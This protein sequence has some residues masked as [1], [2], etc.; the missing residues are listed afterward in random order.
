MQR[1]TDFHL[2]ITIMPHIMALV[3]IIGRIVI[4]V[5]VLI[6]MASGREILAGVD[7]LGAVV[8]IGVVE[9]IGVA[10]MEDGAEDKNSRIV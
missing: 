3:L 7:G 5:T 1:H 4:T 10:A 8:T 2:A 9:A 6:I